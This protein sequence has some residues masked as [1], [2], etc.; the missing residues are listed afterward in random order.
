MAFGLRLAQ[1]VSSA[2]FAPR[3][4]KCYVPAAEASAMYIGQPVVNV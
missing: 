3:I 2:D 1:S 4:R